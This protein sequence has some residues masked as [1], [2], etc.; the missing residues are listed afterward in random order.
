[1]N[2]KFVLNSCACDFSSNTH[3]LPQW[4]FGRHAVM[5]K[6]LLWKKF[7]L[8]KRAAH[9]SK[10]FSFAAGGSSF[11]QTSAEPEMASSKKS[12][13]CGIGSSFTVEWISPCKSRL[14]YKLACAQRL[15]WSDQGFLQNSRNFRA[16]ISNWAS[17]CLCMKRYV[18]HVLQPGL[19][20]EKKKKK[21]HQRIF[22]LCILIFACAEWHAFLQLNI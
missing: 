6:A 15:F 11:K 4:T 19:P 5:F 2:N 1:M 3:L 16:S 21:S 9:L 17:A 7:S 20:S 12:C 22:L 18:G 14:T 8:Q 13:L 10:M